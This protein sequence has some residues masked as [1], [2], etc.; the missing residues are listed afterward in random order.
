[1]LSIWIG[2]FAIAPLVNVILPVEILMIIMQVNTCKKREI[3]RQ[4][5]NYCGGISYENL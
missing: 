2:L 3:S 1:M 4:Q 5:G